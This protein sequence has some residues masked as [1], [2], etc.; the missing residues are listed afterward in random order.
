MMHLCGLG[1][2]FGFLSVCSR[3]QYDIRDD[4]IFEYSTHFSVRHVS[5]EMLEQCPVRE[6]FKFDTYT[7]RIQRRESS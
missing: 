7:F 6:V 1:C 4:T 3:K 2:C 5:Y